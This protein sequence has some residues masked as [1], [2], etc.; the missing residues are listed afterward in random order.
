[1]RPWLLLTVSLLIAISRAQIAHQ[2]NKNKSYKISEPIQGFDPSIPLYYEQFI[3]ISY[4]RNVAIF[5]NDDEQCCQNEMASQGWKRVDTDQPT[6]EDITILKQKFKDENYNYQIL[7]NE[8]YNK[9]LVLFP[10]TRNSAPQLFQE[11]IGLAMKAFSSDNSKVRVMKYFK[12]LYSYLSNKVFNS[13]NRL[14]NSNLEY[15]RYQVIFEGHSLGGAISTLFAYEFA[16]N[17][18]NDNQN[19]P[20]LI[21]YGSPKVGNEA[22]KQSIDKLVPHIFRIVHYGDMVPKIPPNIFGS[23]FYHTKGHALITKDRNTLYEC[24]NNT[25]GICKNVANNPFTVANNHLYYFYEDQRLTKECQRAF[26]I[27][28]S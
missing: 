12:E 17:H 5:A 3:P 20:V 6:N 11:F 23:T 9:I 2:I 8:R 14:L 26:R 21:T 1:M 16:R 15:K 27:N 28:I 24:N 18:R 4:C 25:K 13:L 7:L 10:G 22:F 19:S